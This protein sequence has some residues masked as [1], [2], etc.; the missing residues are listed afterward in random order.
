LVNLITLILQPSFIVARTLIIYTVQQRQE[1]KNQKVQKVAIFDRQ[2]HISTEKIMGA[3][4]F[5]CSF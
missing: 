3:Q 2:L 1:L 4:N 5:N